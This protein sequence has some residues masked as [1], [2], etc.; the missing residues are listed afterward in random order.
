MSTYLFL[1]LLILCGGWFLFFKFQ[2]RIFVFMPEQDENTA[3]Y[4]K[5]FDDMF[6]T[7]LGFKFF[8]ILI[9]VEEQT[10]NNIFFIDWELPKWYRSHKYGQF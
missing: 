1:Y 8:S 2:K 7:I 3:V 9:V 6:F 10:E 5:A 4:M